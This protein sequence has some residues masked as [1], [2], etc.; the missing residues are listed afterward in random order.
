MSKTY[1]N[2]HSAEKS[3]EAQNVFTDELFLYP[4]ERL[5]ISIAGT[6]TATVTLQRQLD[7]ANWRDVPD[8]DGNFG[9]TAPTEQSYVA[10]ESQIV[11]LGVKTGDYTSGTINAR[12]GK[13]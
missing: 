2:R 13:G 11:R 4:G 8:S 10:D 9:W 12:I 3:I 5:S 6:F 1:G 7:G